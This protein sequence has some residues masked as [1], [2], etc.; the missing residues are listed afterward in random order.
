M[1]PFADRARSISGPA[2]DALPVTPDDTNDLPMVAIALYV[3]SG[4][5]VVVDTVTGETR[6]IVVADFS[7]LPLGIRRV[8]T[9]GTTASGLHALVLA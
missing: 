3:E 8:R 6:T 2:T 9:T 7:I 1:N 5:A 4:G